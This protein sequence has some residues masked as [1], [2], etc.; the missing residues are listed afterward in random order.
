MTIT[1]IKAYDC[2]VATLKYWLDKKGRGAQN[3]LSIEAGVSQ[4]LLSLILN[5]K[6][7]KRAGIDSQEAI[8]KAAGFKNYEDAI[9]FGR[10]LIETG[11]PPKPP[12][13]PDHNLIVHVNSQ[14]YKDVVNGTADDYQGIPLYESGRLAAGVN[15]IE[16]DPYQS[17]TS[18]VVV[19]KPELQGRSRH[20]LAAIK[21][22]GDSMEPTII[23]GSIVVVDLS[24]REQVE[25]KVF[26]VNTPEG[27]M[28]MASIKRIKK[29]E[30]GFVLLSDNTNYPLELSPL[31]WNRL[32]VGRIVWMW[33][34][35]SNI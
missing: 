6:T 3:F 12:S 18:V 28:D 7:S 35:I 30:K 21:V 2:F 22:G 20:R 32:C 5:P 29:W 16:F 27:D 1:D 19:Y 25:G 13:P 34:D 26:V 14:Q 10:S 24:D 8:I 11:N 15:G 9:R 17:P 23:K 4:T 33:R 31:D